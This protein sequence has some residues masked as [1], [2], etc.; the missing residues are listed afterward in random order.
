MSK[1][2]LITGASSGIGASTAKKF[3]EE[4]YIVWINYCHNDAGANEVLAEIHKKGGE[5]YLAKFDV[6]DYE[7][8]DKMI[9]EIIEKNGK[10]DVLVNNAGTVFDR[11]FEEITPEQVERVFKVNAIGP[12][13][14]SKKIGEVMLK[15]GYGK[16]V[17]VSSTGGIYDYSP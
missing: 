6:A 10:I 1:V 14:L 17:N 9:E 8:Q 13:F 12:L 4:G 3:A 16:I 2:V 5:A 7:A 11:E 15:N